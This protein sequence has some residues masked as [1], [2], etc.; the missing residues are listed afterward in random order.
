MQSIR[1]SDQY[2]VI[3]AES[4]I[5]SGMIKSFLTG[6][7]DLVFEY[8]DKFYILDYKSNY[9]GDDIQNYSHS[10]LANNIR[11]NGYNLQYY[12]YTAALDKYL[13]KQMNGYDYDLHFG[14]VFYI[15]WRG[16]R[17]GQSSGIFFDR[18]DYKLIERIV[19]DEGVS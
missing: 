16:L 2:G 6:L 3:F 12:L 10:A 1:S 5:N 7:I 19:I 13:D 17:E 14:G 18:P 4:N 11:V 15:Y 9:L 8:Q